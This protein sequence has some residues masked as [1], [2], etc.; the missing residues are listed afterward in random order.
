MLPAP[1]M[2]RVQSRDQLYWF[3]PRAARNPSPPFFCY[4]TMHFFLHFCFI[5]Q[6]FLFWFLVYSSCS[7]YVLTLG[8]D[9]DFKIL[10]TSVTPISSEGLWPSKW[11]KKKKEILLKEKSELSAAIIIGCDASQWQSLM[12][13]IASNALEWFWGH[14]SSCYHNELVQPLGKTHFSLEAD[15]LGIICYSYGKLT[16]PNLHFCF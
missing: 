13:I 6:I 10:L 15:F 16:D 8:F 2:T 14:S 4:L 7:W 11:K 9:F 3:Q 12:H 1:C 5:R